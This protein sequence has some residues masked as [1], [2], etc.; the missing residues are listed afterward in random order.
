MDVT[1]IGELIS[2]YGFPIIMCGALFWYMIKQNEAHQSETSAL[3][4]AI[5]KLEL[6][7]TKLYERLG[8]Q[9]NDD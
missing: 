3:R 9:N 4:E 8:G 7:I 1:Q 6:A 2:V 5:T